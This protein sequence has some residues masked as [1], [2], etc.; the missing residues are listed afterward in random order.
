MLEPGLVHPPSVPSLN[1]GLTFFFFLRNLGN[2]TFPSSLQSL[3]L[4]HRYLP[5]YMYIRN[6]Y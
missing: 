3:P 4:Q 2:V 6:T 1:S 5:F